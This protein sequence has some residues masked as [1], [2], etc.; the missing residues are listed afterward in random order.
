MENANLALKKLIHWESKPSVS[1]GAAPIIS[2]AFVS[3]PS[4]VSWGPHGQ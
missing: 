3:A 1:V 4:E 2:V